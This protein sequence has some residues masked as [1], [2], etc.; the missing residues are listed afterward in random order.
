MKNTIRKKI[1]FLI[2]IFASPVKGMV[3]QTSEIAGWFFLSHSQ[4]LVK[5]WSYMTDIQLRSS[6][7]FK[8]LQN[9]LLRPG[10]LYKITDNH[11]VGIGY[12]YFASW[13]NNKSPHTFDPENRIFEQYI[14]ELELGRLMLNNRFRLEQRFIQKTGENVFA[15][16]FR[17]QVQAKFRLNSDI[18]FKKGWYLKLQNEIFLN[19]QNKENTNNNFFDQN[20]PY[21]ALGYRF[22]KKIETEI[23]YYHRYQ[24]QE[25]SRKN[26]PVIQ[27]MVITD[28]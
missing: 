2:I 5:K 13:D 11:S 12:T 28:L 24:L 6:P 25:D 10:L 8:Y 14:L 9:I 4:K 1:I 16:R 19:I 26:D 15:Q 17:H 20:R 18:A 7:G 3:A 23:G 21:I 22:T 27:L